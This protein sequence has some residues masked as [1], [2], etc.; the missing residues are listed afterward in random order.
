MW[1]ETSEHVVLR[2]LRSGAVASRGPSAQSK[3]TMR[4]DAFHGYL[5]LRVQPSVWVLQHART[6]RC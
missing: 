4:R 2:M 1:T 5:L 6:V 3:S